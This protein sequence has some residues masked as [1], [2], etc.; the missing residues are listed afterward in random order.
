[1]PPQEE[2]RLTRIS[3]DYEV[4]NHGYVRKV[5]TG[6]LLKCFATRTELLTVSLVINDKT[7]PIAVAKLV[8][9][10][11]TDN[12]FWKWGRG[13]VYKDGNK[14]NVALDNLKYAGT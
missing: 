6:K 12:D 2:W 10:A 8:L 5:S 14:K 4:S 1:M 13:I 3:Q 7:K 11:F 9:E